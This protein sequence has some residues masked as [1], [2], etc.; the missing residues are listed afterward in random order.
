[1]K[2]TLLITL[3]LFVNLGGAILNAQEDIT[4][5]YISNPSFED[6][7]AVELTECK[8]YGTTVHGMG[9]C[10]MIEGSVEHGYDYT[11]TNWTLLEQNTN[12][13]GG[14][15]IYGNKVQYTKSGFESVPSTGPLATS[16]TKALCF[17]GNNNLIYQQPTEV[18]LPAGSY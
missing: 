17:C 11:S 18:S 15:V 6:C 13:N 10:L 14:V 8:G 1:M 9:H 4:S 12:A 3:S 16:G 5:Q 2:K 7:D